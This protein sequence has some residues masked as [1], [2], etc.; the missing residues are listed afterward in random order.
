MKTILVFLIIVLLVSGIFSEEV[1]TALASE[2]TKPQTS[3]QSLSNSK[4]IPAVS[5]TKKSQTP[6]LTKVTTPAIQPQIKPGTKSTTSKVIPV[7]KSTITPVLPKSSALKV[8]A[9]V[10]KQQ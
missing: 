5:P 7:G 1:K 6:L 3:S 4:Q 2:L 9:R 8:P 10:V